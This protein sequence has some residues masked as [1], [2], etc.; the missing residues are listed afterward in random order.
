MDFL[1]HEQKTRLLTYY[2]GVVM[3]PAWN[4]VQGG[5]RMSP[6]IVF[7]ATPHSDEFA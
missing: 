3:E 6:E 2:L 1:E 4:S 7:K 5:E